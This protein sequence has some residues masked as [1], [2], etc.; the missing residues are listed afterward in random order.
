M[1]QLVMEKVLQSL[2]ADIGLHQSEIALIQTFIGKTG[3]MIL[4]QQNTIDKLNMKVG[5]C[6]QRIDTMAKV[7]EPSRIYLHKISGLGARIQVLE[8]R[9]N[10]MKGS[11]TGADKPTF[12]V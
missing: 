2:H 7:L 5:E 12:R 8:A 10:S 4:K 9:L 11:K 6:L 3:E 1:D